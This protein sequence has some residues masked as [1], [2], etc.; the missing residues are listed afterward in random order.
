[1]Q[2]GLGTGGPSVR[3]AGCGAPRHGRGRKV[4]EATEGV[5]QG[6]VHGLHGEVAKGVRDGVVGRGGRLHGIGSDSRVGVV[7][8]SHGEHLHFREPFM[9]VLRPRTSL[10]FRIGRALRYALRPTPKETLARLSATSPRRTRDA[11]HGELIIRG[12]ANGLPPGLSNN[13]IHHRRGGR[14]GLLARRAAGFVPRSLIQIGERVPEA[15]AQVGGAAILLL[16]NGVLHDRRPHRAVLLVPGLERGVFLRG[17]RA[18]FLGARLLEERGAVGQGGADL[19]GEMRFGV[20][21]VLFVGVWEVGAESR[22]QKMSKFCILDAIFYFIYLPVFEIDGR[23]VIEFEDGIFEDG[24][25]I[26]YAPLSKRSQQDEGK[27]KKE[28]RT[29]LQPSTSI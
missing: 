21:V 2:G 12:S 18:S 28:E 7:G 6:V 24:F 13:S 16:E 17:E 29:M 11:A 22:T 20:G 15:I 23:A 1:M 3:V 25:P 9:V 26:T 27:G 19:G 14:E 4:G 8:S 5:V 10:V